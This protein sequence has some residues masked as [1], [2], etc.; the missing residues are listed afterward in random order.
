M[1]RLTVLLLLAASIAAQ[2]TGANEQLARAGR[3]PYDLARFVD[4]HPRFDW[5]VLWKAFGIEPLVYQPCGGL[6]DAGKQCSTELIS[7]LDPD[8]V[9]LVIQG[10][11]TPTDIYLRFMQEK[12][13]N[14]RFAGAHQ[15]FI[16]NHPRRHEVD[17][18]AGKPF[19][20]IS[21]QGISGSGV[22]SEIDNWFDLTQPSFESVFS[23]TVQGYQQAIGFR[24]GRK[25]FGIATQER[26]AIDVLLEVHFEGGGRILS[27]KH[28]NAVYARAPGA[29]E[30]SFQTAYDGMDRKTRISRAEFD[31]LADVDNGPSNEDLIQYAM[32]G[33]KEI[34]AGPDGD[35]KNWLRRV[36]TLVKDTPEVRELKALMRH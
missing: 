13:G 5:E 11:S 1:F 14:W 17:R 32:P 35:A 20:R 34:A 18:S 10:D 33:L 8:Q 29:R 30:F 26:D 15:A 24:I 12:N 36:L 2:N 16:R 21:A 9:I 22:D 3:N 4:S 23:F 31:P 25:I 28:Y 6:S 7:V 27:V 19:L